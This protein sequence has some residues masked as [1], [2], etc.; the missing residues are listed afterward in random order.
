MS[1]EVLRIERRVYENGS[2]YLVTRLYC[3]LLTKFCTL[4]RTIAEFIGTMRSNESTRGLTMKDYMHSLT[5]SLKR[6][7]SQEVRCKRLKSS[8]LGE[9]IQSYEIQESDIHFTTYTIISSCHAASMGVKQ[10][11]ES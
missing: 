7:E 6:H 1:C 3:L 5:N 2:F 4:S 11:L 8:H 10:H 9:I